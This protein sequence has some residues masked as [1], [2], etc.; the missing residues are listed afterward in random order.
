MCKKLNHCETLKRDNF[1]RHVK[2]RA[3]CFRS[4]LLILPVITLFTGQ[5]LSA[6]DDEKEETHHTTVHTK[7]FEELEQENRA[8]KER[9]NKPKS[10]AADENS[11]VI[12]GLKFLGKAALMGLGGVL[13]IVSIGDLV[14]DVSDYRDGQY[15]VPEGNPVYNEGLSFV[16]KKAPDEFIGR[17]R[18]EHRRRIGNEVS[19][20]A[21]TG[22][23]LK[24]FF[25]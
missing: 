16:G 6:M 4:L 17:M 18:T 21:K 7:T 24:N 15:K 2:Q 9:L 11:P 23:F 19:E 10:D 14:H 22:E 5:P 3:N 25:D 8:L 1:E 13:A 12:E 20:L